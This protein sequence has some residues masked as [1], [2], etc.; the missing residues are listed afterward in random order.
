MYKILTL[1]ASTVAIV[2][3]WHI[4][5][6]R[7]ASGYDSPAWQR[8]SSRGAYVNTELSGMTLLGDQVVFKAAP[9]MT[10]DKKSGKKVP[11]KLGQSSYVFSACTDKDGHIYALSDIHGKIAVQKQTGDRW[12]QM[13]V[14]DM[15]AGQPQDF[16]IVADQEKLA[17]VSSAAIFTGK[18]GRWS[19]VFS[20]PKS[21]EI[22]SA[23][24]SS[25][26][27]MRAGKVYVSQADGDKGDVLS[28]DLQNGKATKIYNGAAVPFMALSKDDQ[29]WFVTGEKGKSSLY[30]LDVKQAAKPH[31]E[32]STSGFRYNVL[33]RIGSVVGGDPLKASQAVNWP[34]EPTW[35]SGLSVLDDNSVLVATRDYGLLKYRDGKWEKLTAYWPD[36]NALNPVVTDIV[37]LASPRGENAV[38]AVKRGGLVYYDLA[39]KRYSFWLDPA[40]PQ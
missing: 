2:C 35:F 39:K 8:L 22:V 17:L 18:S 3:V 5:S 20:G 36:S 13:A 21:K 33:D 23:M 24:P 38:I 1:F 19:Q 26:V 34:Y 7:Q 32:A 6:E 37:G 25:Q 31:L 12:Q 9:L 28:I 14:P 10:M 27:I 11:L 15:V 30:S 40:L 29:L 16:Q 4:Y